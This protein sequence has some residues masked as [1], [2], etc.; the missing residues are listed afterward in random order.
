MMAKINGIQR[1]LVLS[2]EKFMHTDNCFMSIKK[3]LLLPDGNFL[4][5]LQFHYFFG[6]KNTEGLKKKKSLYWL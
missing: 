3:I 5:C 1:L 4:F 6:E 2:E